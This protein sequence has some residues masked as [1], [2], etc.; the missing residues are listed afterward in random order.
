MILKNMLQRLRACRQPIL[1]ELIE[2]R[3]ALNVWSQPTDVSIRNGLVV[4]A[5]LLRDLTDYPNPHPTKWFGF[6]GLIATADA[7][8][9]LKNV[10]KSSDSSPRPP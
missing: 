7:G 3:R 9:N 2:G 10:F 5:T 4:N 6:V 1:Y 8:K